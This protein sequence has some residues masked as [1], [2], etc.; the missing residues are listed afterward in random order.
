VLEEGRRLS[1]H[2]QLQLVASRRQ[3]N[4]RLQRTPPHQCTRRRH[5]ELVPG[6]H[7]PANLAGRP[8]TKTVAARHQRNL[9]A[10][11]P[12]L[13]HRPRLAHRPPPSQPP[14][15]RPPPVH[16]L[17]A[18]RP[19]PTHLPLPRIQP[20]QAP[21]PDPTHIP[22]NLLPPVHPQIQSDQLPD[23]SGILFPPRSSRLRPHCKKHSRRG[24]MK[25][26]GTSDLDL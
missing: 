23:E 25:T 16:H 5:L 21:R 18:H 15:H 19:A 11:R 9:A 10:H 20:W 7:R 3:E 12:R 14:P 26:L 4:E 6:R 8:L 22:P 17:L 13:V 24:K 1:A 2:Q